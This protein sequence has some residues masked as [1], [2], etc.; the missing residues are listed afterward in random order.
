MHIHDRSD[1]VHR[2]GDRIDQSLRRL[3]TPPGE[4]G[5]PQ[6]GTIR[7]TPV[8]RRCPVPT[9]LVPPIAHDKGHPPILLSSHSDRLGPFRGSRFSKRGG[10]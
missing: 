9:R 3:A 6:L 4:P 1:R 8:H 10:G 5:L 2:V 7:D